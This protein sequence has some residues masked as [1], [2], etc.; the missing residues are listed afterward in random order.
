MTLTPD[1][2][3]PGMYFLDPAFIEDPPGSGL[4]VFDTPNPGGSSAV[5]PS[6]VQVGSLLLNVIDANNTAWGLTKFD[7]W[8]TPKPTL[9]P[10]PHV[11]RS[12]YTMGDSFSE[13]RVM[14]L[15]VTVASATPAQHTI[16]CDT[17][18]AAFPRTQT[19]MYVSESGRVRWTTIRRSAEIVPTHFSAITTS[20]IIQVTSKDWRKFGT[21]LTNTTALRTSSGGYSF[22]LSYPM[23]IPAVSNSGQISFTNPGN[24]IGPVV[25]RVDGPCPGPVIT[26]SGPSGQTTFASSLALAA[27]EWIDIDMEKQTVRA[28]GGPGR[29]AFIT[30]RQWS[31]FE[32]GLNTWAF[33]ASSYDPAAKLTITATPSWE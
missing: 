31:G 10:L 8:G 4:Y 11:R 29:N 15:S 12:G 26:H 18:I 27:G 3:A 5:E 32:P 2:S 24:E 7:G 23:S 13:G 14:T 20:F 9:A 28:N 1:P 33:D 25:A 17:L 6:T 22:P 21:A 16:D 30:S 19:I